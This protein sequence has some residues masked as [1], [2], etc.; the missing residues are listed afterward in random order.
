MISIIIP[1]LIVSQCYVY[2][3]A[4]T[5]FLP[6]DFKSS[7]I[8]TLQNVTSLNHSE[9]TGFHQVHFMDTITHV[10]NT[11]EITDKITEKRGE[12]GLGLTSY[13]AKSMSYEKG[14]TFEGSLVMPDG[15]LT[16]DNGVRK[17]NVEFRYSPP[18]KEETLKNSYKRVVEA[19]DSN[20]LNASESRNHVSIV[21][22]RSQELSRK[23][24]V[25][26]DPRKFDL[27]SAQN[28]STIPEDHF[29]KT[30]EIITKRTK[31]EQ[32]KNVSITLDGLAQYDISNF[33]SLEMPSISISQMNTLL[34][35]SH[36]SSCLKV[37]IPTR[38]SKLGPLTPTWF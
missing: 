19:E 21:S 13:A 31:T 35:L 34:S 17:M 23:S 10:K 38:S 15:K 25:I 18:M 27:S 36:N 26:V 5:S 2:P 16:V 4:K 30:E 1:I 8:T 28:V 14:G 20:Y 32:R 37:W 7:N 24:V 22:N 33:K 3:Y 9:I 29:N 12:R 6:L 11:K